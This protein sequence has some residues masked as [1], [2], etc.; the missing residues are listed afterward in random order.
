MIRMMSGGDE[1]EKLEHELREFA[2]A[3]GLAD[4][5][6]DEEESMEH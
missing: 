3:E 6:H 4:A 2:E 1:L 5:I